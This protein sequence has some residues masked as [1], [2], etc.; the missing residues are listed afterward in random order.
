MFDVK[1]K[2]C[3]PLYASIG[4][5]PDIDCEKVDWEVVLNGIKDKKVKGGNAHQ[6]L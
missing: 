1:L 6:L 4:I 5:E 2:K 3:K